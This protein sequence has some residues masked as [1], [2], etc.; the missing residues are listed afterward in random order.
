[1]I[2]YVHR[3]LA[4]WGEWSMVRADGGYMGG[5]QFSYR[6]QIPGAPKSAEALSKI[7]ANSPALEMEMGVAWLLKHETRIGELVCDYYRDT[8]QLKVEYIAEAHRVS[9]RTFFRYVDKAHTLLLDWLMGRSIGE[10]EAD[11]L[12]A[13][14]KYVAKMPKIAAK[15]GCCG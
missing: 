13:W 8:P 14:D 15:D 10:H 12:E 11:M 5:G 7:L 9:E 3:R 1:M 4:A 6:E 2:E